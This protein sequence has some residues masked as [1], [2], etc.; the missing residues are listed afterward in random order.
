M[1]NIIIVSHN[2]YDDL[3]NILQEIG[4]KSADYSIFIRDNIND[5]HLRQL[6][7]KY[8]VAYSA[9]LRREGFAL[10]NNI[11]AEKIVNTSALGEYFLFMN[12]DAFITKGELA[13]LIKLLSYKKPEMFTV[14][15]YNNEAYTIRDPSIRAFPKLTTFLTSFLFGCNNSI[16]NRDEIGESTELDWCASS[17]F[18]IKSEIF[19]KLGGFDS[20]FFMY[21]EDVDLC[22]RAK[23]HGVK[24]TY[25]PEIKAI[26]YAQMNSKKMLSRN[27][28]WHFKSA[29]MFL[30]KKN[31][32][33]KNKI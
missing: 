16:I 1:V 21:C 11:E 18:G 10:N 19:I 27:F 24:L 23:L 2:N 4:C 22:Y 3:K 6:C 12:P 17:F 31:K 14:D 13:K 8:D 28:F 9:A 20:K 30:W 33:S 25:L 29:I 32:I 7:L 26:H 15:L 5:E